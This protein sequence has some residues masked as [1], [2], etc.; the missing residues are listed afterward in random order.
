MIGAL[1]LAGCDQPEQV[2]ERQ[3]PARSLVFEETVREPPREVFRRALILPPEAVSV[4]LFVHVGDFSDPEKTFVEPDG[5][6][7]TRAQRKTFEDALAVVGYD[8]EADAVAACFVPHHFLR[9]YDATG[10]QVGEIAVC[11]CCDGVSATPDM[12]G[13]VPADVKGAQIIFGAELRQAVEALGLPVDV[14]C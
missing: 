10:R 1:S 2:Q 7:L 3:Y 6:R 12:I 14:R 13:S 9:Y 8:R 4:R 11:F 5:R